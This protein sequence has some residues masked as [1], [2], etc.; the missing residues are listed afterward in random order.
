MQI[1]KRP[2]VILIFIGGITLTCGAVKH[3]SSCVV[4]KLTAAPV[5]GVSQKICGEAGCTKTYYPEVK[6]YCGGCGGVGTETRTA[7][8]DHDRS[9]EYRY[10]YQG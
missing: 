1:W 6:I 9:Q 5:D 3:S 4:S 7:C 2:I 10:V 8:Y